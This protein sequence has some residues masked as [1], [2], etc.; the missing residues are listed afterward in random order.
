MGLKDFLIKQG[1]ITEKEGVNTPDAENDTKQQQTTDPV[2][3]TFFPLQGDN[4]TTNSGQV[5]EPAFVAPIKNNPGSVQLDPSFVKFF[6][7]ELVKSNLPGPDYFEFRQLLNKTKQKM[8]GKGMASDDLILHTVLMSFE[9]QDVSGAKLVEAARKYK[10]IIRKKNDD[11]LAGAANEKNS[12]LQKRQAA[13]QTREAN[14]QKIQSQ[15]VQ[16]ENQKRQLED[17]LAKEKTQSEVDK[18]LGKEGIAKIERAEQMINLA[19]AYI[20]GT[21]DADIQRLQSS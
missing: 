6:E 1:F 5:S 19:H 10:E 4:T 13:L 16:L 18:T 12:Q 14:I 15:L 11:F 20:Q 2:T 17:A 9:A 21:I 8:E 3:P 7:D